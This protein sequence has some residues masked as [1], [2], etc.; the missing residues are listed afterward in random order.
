MTQGCFRFQS[1]C[2]LVN[3][4]KIKLSP[5]E[6]DIPHNLPNN[7][8]SPTPSLDSLRFVCVLHVPVRGVWGSGAFGV[9]DLAGAASAMVVV[10]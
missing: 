9:S 1:P 2:C 10:S 4:N 3:K 6:P 7:I 5:K 8:P